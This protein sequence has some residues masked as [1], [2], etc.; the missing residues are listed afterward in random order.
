MIHFIYEENPNSYRKPIL[1]NVDK[2]VEYARKYALNY[3]LDYLTFDEIGG[4]CTNFISQCLYA[5]G[6]P[7]TNNWH[8]YSFPWI[9]VNDLYYYLINNGYAKEIPMNGSFKAGNIIQFFSKSKGFFAHTGIIT[10]VLPS[11]DY[12][13]CCHSYD[14]L[15]FPLSLIYPRIYDK[16]RIL[17]IIY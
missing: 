4:D 15:D 17:D 6:L 9:R 12:L 11:G 7:K 3:N 10:K 2:A 16:F 5:G 1:F 14:K 8:P 13:Y